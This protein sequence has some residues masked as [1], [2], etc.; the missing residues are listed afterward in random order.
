MT[1]G[2]LKEPSH[3]TRVSLLAEALPLSPKKD[4]TVL[5]EKM[6]VKK[7]FAAMK[8]MKKPGHRSKSRNEILASSD[9]IL[10]IHQPDTI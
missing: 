7:H 1:I 9:I 10:A 8:I 6:P 2:I 3:E 4:I 5:V